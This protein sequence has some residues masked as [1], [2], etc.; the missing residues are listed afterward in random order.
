MED[1]RPKLATLKLDGELLGSI[2][3]LFMRLSQLGKYLDL[4]FEYFEYSTIE[5][6]IG[7]FT[8]CQQG[9]DPL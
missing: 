1:D 3:A 4:Y 9:F 2:F 7:L 8:F 6:L 5:S